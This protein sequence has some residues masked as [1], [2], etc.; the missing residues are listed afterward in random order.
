MYQ[1]SKAVLGQFE[2]AGVVPKRNLAEFR[3]TEDAV[4]P[5]GT[6]VTASYFTA[7]QYV[8]VCGTR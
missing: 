6:K 8:D 7:G 2:K 5:V 3:I 1:V 4:L